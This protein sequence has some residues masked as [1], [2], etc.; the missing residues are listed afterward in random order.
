MTIPT[1]GGTVRAAE[2]QRH[3]DDAACA[4][5]QRG[6]ALALAVLL[7]AAATGYFLAGPR[8]LDAVL[9]APREN[10]SYVLIERFTA[11]Q[12]IGFPLRYEQ[13]LPPDIALA[14]TP[15]DA[16]KVDGEVVPQDFAGTVLTYA[17]LFRIWKPLALLVAPLLAAA[18]AVLIL[19]LARE[20]FEPDRRARG[21]V[22]GGWVGVGLAA[23]W[24][25]HPGVAL[26]GSLV[27]DLSHAATVLVLAMTLFFVRYLRRGG[28]RDLALMAVAAGA[29]TTVRYQ[30]A[31]I[32]LI[33]FVALAVMRNLSLRRLGIVALCLAPFAAAILGFNAFAYGD[34]FTT[35]YHVRRDITRAAMP[36]TG[37]LIPT[38]G[39]AARN[40]LWFYAI[41]NPVVLVPALL[42]LLSAFA[43][44]RRRAQRAV[45]WPLLL[46]TVVYFAYHLGLGTWGSAS[47]AM[48]ASFIRY[49]LPVLAIWLALLWGSARAL[50]GRRAT[51][52]A[53]A[54]LALI[55]VSALTTLQGPVGIAQR[56]RQLK[57]DTRI[58]ERVLAHTGSGALIAVSVSDRSLFPARQTLT[59]AYLVDGGEARAPD[60]LRSVWERWPSP[61]R[62]ADVAARVLAEGIPLYLLDEVPEIDVG[63]YRRALAERSL[64]L[65]MVDVV[66]FDQPLLFRVSRAAPAPLSR[67]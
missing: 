52:A 29:A 7:V 54:L 41:R 30:T 28:T 66:P 50:R 13:R 23:L 4:R 24:L 40:H 56:Q 65:D 5:G 57:A 59:L 36:G 14:L 37:A 10:V 21:R 58:R 46:A 1:A 44:L 61:D 42:G 3:R 26:N 19:L 62:F 31:I 22:P 48:N 32:A 55:G 39:I 47:P 67:S 25:A 6:P 35:G 16:A 33:L 49:I 17:A 9:G 51:L 63:P 60:G 20:L 12:G 38:D 2:E 43:L 34:P 8:S 27:I 53:V 45:L 11:G 64:G 15:R 18:G